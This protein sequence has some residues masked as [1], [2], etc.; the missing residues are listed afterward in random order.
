[1][2]LLPAA[3]LEGGDG[4]PGL[5]IAPAMMNPDSLSMIKKGMARR[6][7]LMTTIYN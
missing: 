3:A 5:N 6:L 4:S 1:M 2:T 7:W